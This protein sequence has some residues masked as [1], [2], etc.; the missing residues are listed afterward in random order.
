VI[1]GGPRFSPDELPLEGG[2][3]TASGIAASMAVARELDALMTAPA[4]SPSLGF[5]SRVMAAVAA[6]PAPEPVMAFAQALV[7]GRFTAMAAAVRDAWRVAAS[8]G[9]PTPV[10]AQAFALVLLVVL[11]FGSVA[12]I[13]AGAVG[14]LD[15]GPRN[16][17]PLPTRPAVLLPRPS[18]RPPAQVPPSTS[19]T[20]S[21]SPKPAGSAAPTAR[22]TTRPV[23]TPRR[24]AS[25][26]PTETDQPDGSDDASPDDTAPPADG[27]ASPSDNRGPG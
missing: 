24:T 4:P 20:P 11:S 3:V 2:R 15:S 16:P 9:R 7:G 18:A 10:R 26:R 27:A 19:S 21:A 14:L 6:E 23:A 1:G 22:P 8:A 13:A 25:P 5:T 12:G 17:A